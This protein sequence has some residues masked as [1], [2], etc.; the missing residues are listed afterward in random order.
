MTLIKSIPFVVLFAFFVSTAQGS[1]SMKSEMETEFSGNWIGKGTLDGQGLDHALPADFQISVKVTSTALHLLECWKPADLEAGQ[2]RCI[3]SEYEIQDENKLYSKGRRLG[4]IFPDQ[5]TILESNSQVA[6]QMVL[7]LSE[8]KQLRFQY[9]YVN[10][11]G[12]SQFRK[13]ILK[14]EKP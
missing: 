14:R 3:R 5:I 13:A 6:E 8:S 1:T 11:D 12:A 4:E 10:V 7:Q 9:H 2:P